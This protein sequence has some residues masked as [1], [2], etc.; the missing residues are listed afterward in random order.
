MPVGRR[1]RL[2]VE[3]LTAVPPDPRVCTSGRATR[4][5]R[6]ARGMR[7]SAEPGSGSGPRR[8]PARC[9]VTDENSRDKVQNVCGDSSAIG[10]LYSYE[11]CSRGTIRDVQTGIVK[12]ETAGRRFDVL[13]RSVQRSTTR[14]ASPER[15][16]ASTTN[17]SARRSAALPHPR[18]HGSPTRDGLPSTAR[19]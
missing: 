6:N 2:T 1:G 18:R 14:R 12:T 17:R 10:S 4:R 5:T 7:R 8:V 13:R 15:C 19:R 9:C 16:E 3:C 11:K